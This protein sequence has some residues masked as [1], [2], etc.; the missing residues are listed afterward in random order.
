MDGFRKAGS[1]SHLYNKMMESTQELAAEEAELVFP[2]GQSN[3][4]CFWV[5]GRIH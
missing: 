3:I 4:A 1:D 2:A 5:L